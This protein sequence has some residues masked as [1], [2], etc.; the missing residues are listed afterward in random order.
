M[1]AA[2]DHAAVAEDADSLTR[3]WKFGGD[4]DNGL[5]KVQ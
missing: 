1:K 4:K 2:L 3:E 5:Y